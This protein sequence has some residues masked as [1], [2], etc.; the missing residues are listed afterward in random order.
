MSDY[1]ITTDNMADLP[2]EYTKEHDM[3]VLSLTYMIDGESYNKERELPY[4]EFYAK[5]RAGSMPTTSQVNPE[6]AKKVFKDT[7]K[8]T[9]NII[10]IAFSGSMSGS[11]A[12]A[13]I[14]AKEIMEEEPDCRIKV[15]DS[16]CAAMGQGLY[17]CLAEQKR[18]EGMAF[19]ELIE[20]LEAIKLHVIHNV[21][22]DDLFHLFRGGR[23]SKAAA[24]VGSMMNLKPMLELNDEGRLSP[25]SKS[26][27]RKR[28]M[29]AMVD[30]MDKQIGEWR[31]KNELITISHGDCL[32]DAEYLQSLVKERFGFEK[33]MITPLGPTIGAHAGPGTLALFYLGDQR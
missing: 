1:M 10:H 9:K 16:L 6:E 13:R 24:I 25:R 7:L 21:M 33:F 31:D 19:E 12:S 5:M 17:V 3:R 4:Q 2:D 22:V 28:T 11:F 32:E 23:L 15:I 20:W 27:G 14:A 8:K 26:R 30:R 18:A 29:V